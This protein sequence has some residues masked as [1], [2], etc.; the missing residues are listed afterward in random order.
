MEDFVSV[1]NDIYNDKEYMLEMLNGGTYSLRSKMAI[2]LRYYLATRDTKKRSFSEIDSLYK[3]IEESNDPRL[4]ANAQEYLTTAFNGYKKE[5]VQKYGL[6]SDSENKEVKAKRRKD[7]ELLEKEIGVSGYASKD[8]HHNA[9]KGEYTFIGVP[10]GTPNDMTFYY[11]YK[12]SPER[13][14]E[15]PLKKVYYEHIIGETK[16]ATYRRELEELVN[17][18]I[19]NYEEVLSAIKNITDTYCSKPPVIALVKRKAINNAYHDFIGKKKVA[20][21]EE[22]N[23]KNVKAAFCGSALEN[24]MVTTDKIAP[25]DIRIVE[26]MDLDRLFELRELE[27]GAKYGDL[28]YGGSGMEPSL[29]VLAGGINYAES[30]KTVQQF[31]S[32]YEE[33]Y[34]K[35]S[36]SVRTAFESLNKK[37]L[38][39]SDKEIGDDTEQY[40]S[41]L[42]GTSH[43]RR[44]NFYAQLLMQEHGIEGRDKEIILAA[45][46]NHDIGRRNDREDKEHGT[47]SYEKATE[48][49]RFKD[50]S[51]QEQQIIKF[52]IERTFKE[53]ERKHR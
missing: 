21:N 37:E 51:E 13:V 8:I 11:A 25:E 9:T 15:G 42:H 14:F 3:Q 53:F 5:Q 29:E 1:L 20:V 40:K 17:P 4:I 48:L 52:I 43:T 41:R 34:K 45:V 49:G 32:R 30:Q 6:N 39:K 50:F 18:K 16:R 27:N 47:L 24:D 31:K 19:E 35:Q 33:I 22:R 38:L 46:Q 44:V 2:I 10:G 28:I 36:D 26:L 23:Y 12:A 7:L